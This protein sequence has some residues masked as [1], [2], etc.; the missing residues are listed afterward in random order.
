[1]DQYLDVTAF[2]NITARDADGVVV[3][4]YL[5]M[6]TDTANLLK[7]RKE[8][9]VTTGAL[10]GS[11]PSYSFTTGNDQATGTITFTFNRAISKRS[12]NIT[13]TQQ[14]TGYR[15]PAVLTED[16]ASCLLRYAIGVYFFVYPY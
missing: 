15:L 16:Q 9:L 13:V 11:D 4:D 8:I 5:K 14:T 6:P 3:N 7:Y 10:T 12:G 2:N 1:R